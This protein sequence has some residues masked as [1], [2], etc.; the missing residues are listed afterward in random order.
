VTSHI[1]QSLQ[2]RWFSE[3]LCRRSIE[4]IHVTINPAQPRLLEELRRLG[5]P[6]YHLRHSSAL[7]HL[8]NLVRLCALLYRHR[9]NVVHSELPYGNA[10]GQLAAVLCGIRRRVTT[11]SNVTWAQDFHSRKQAVIDRLTYALAHH[12]I[13]QTDLS[14]DYLIEKLGLPP[15]SITTIWHALRLE[16]Y[17]EIAA[18]RVE[19][20]RRALGL[21]AADFV[22]GMLARF[23]AWKGHRHAVEAMRAVV[24]AEPSAKLLLFGLGPDQEAVRDL[25]RSLD[26]TSNVFFPGYVDDIAAVYRLFDVHL[27]VP[28]NPMVE[29]FGLTLIEGMVS[30]CAQ[31]VTRSGISYFTAKHLENAYVVDYAAPD[32]IAAGILALRRDPRLR[33]RLGEAARIFAAG[34]FL[35]PEKVDRHLAVYARR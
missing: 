1:D 4:H 3:E 28:V 17:R 29:S 2:W 30:G 8:P 35:Y 32:Q 26:L 13:A 21:D 18:D 34:T 9:I 15:E 6:A 27:H 20:L 12:V 25:S 7:S 16:A 5:V 14:R 10:L 11:C 24:D 22:I 23:E 33:A 31:V 19:S